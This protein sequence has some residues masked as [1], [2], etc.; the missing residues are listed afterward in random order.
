MFSFFF[1]NKESKLH[2]K[3]KRVEEGRGGEMREVGCHG[4]RG[5]ERQRGKEAAKRKEKMRIVKGGK[6]SWE[7][8]LS[9]SSYDS[10]EL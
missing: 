8:V 7:I 3:G 10:F 5:E 4:K 9:I 1:F 2:R 6:N